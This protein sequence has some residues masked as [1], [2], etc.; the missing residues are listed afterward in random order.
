MTDRGGVFYVAN[1]QPI[2]TTYQVRTYERTDRIF[3]VPTQE[4]FVIAP[5]P[6]ARR[7]TRDPV[8]QRKKA[9]AQK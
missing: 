9:T 3:C 5:R 1:L 6:P 7:Q 4:I 2:L 8:T